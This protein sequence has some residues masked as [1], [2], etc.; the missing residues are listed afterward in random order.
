VDARLDHPVGRLRAQRA[1]G[2][3]RLQRARP[4]SARADVRPAATRG[5]R[6]N[7][8]CYHFLDAASR[9]FFVDWD[10]AARATAALLRVEAG[11]EP[12]DRALRELIGE[13]S[14]RSRDFRSMW[15]AHDVRIRHDGVKRLQHPEVGRL[16]LT[17]RSLDLPTAERG[18]HDLTLYTAEPGTASED[19][20]KLLAS[21]SATPTPSGEPLE[22]GGHRA[23]S[24]E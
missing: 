7:F 2:R 24:A 23:V 1:D 9:D 21:W 15:A 10:A 3:R 6:P 18:V 14:T 4:S 19:R 5:G 16:E 22:R 20:L 8:A 11:R 13:L 12:H 17:Y